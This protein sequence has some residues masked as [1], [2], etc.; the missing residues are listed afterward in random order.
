M[1]VVPY[2]RLNR[3]KDLFK[4]SLLL[5]LLFCLLVYLLHWHSGMAVVPHLRLNRSKDLFKGRL[6]WGLLFCLLVH[7]L[8]WHS[9]MAVVQYMRQNRRKDSF[10]GRLLWVLL[11]CLLVHLLYW[12]SVMAVIPGIDVLPSNAPA[13][14]IFIYHDRPCRQNMET[15][16]GIQ[17][18][19]VRK[20]IRG[21]VPLTNGS[22]SESNSFFQNIKDAK[23]FFFMF[24][25][26]TS[27]GT[28][29][30]VL[31][32][33]FLLKL[34]QNLILQALFPLNTFMRKGRIRILTSD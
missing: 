4:G 5:G 17:V 7:L 3:C 9:G 13:A 29:S 16:L 12:H 23:F 28:L 34:Y 33:K 30:S 32:F 6:L 8:H 21:F 14:M 26:L 2:M 15:V 24:L 11:N 22:G 25:S 19:L 10:K 31:K 1:A 18:L 20:W 27:A